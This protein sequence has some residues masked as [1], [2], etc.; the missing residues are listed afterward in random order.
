MPHELTQTQ[1]LGQNDHVQRYEQ[2]E[3]LRRAV[4]KSTLRKLDFILLPFL[5]LLFLFNAID[6]SNIGNA[7]SAHFTSDLGLQKDDL[8][9][10]VA[11]FFAFFVALQPVGAALGRKYGMVHFVPT[12]MA[13][14]G[15]STAL[16]VWVRS[17]WQ[18]YSLRIIIGCLEAGFYPVTVSYL[19]L[20][21]TRFE[22][23][24]RL[25][26]FYGQAAVGAAV[27]GILSYLVFSRFANEPTGGDQGVVHNGWK[28]WQVLFLLEGCTTIVI[29]LIGFLWL[30]HN[31][32]TAWFL[33]HQERKW[34]EQRIILDRVGE[35]G[36]SALESDLDG[37]EIDEEES[38]GLLNPTKVASPSTV[39]T[40]DRG[41]TPHDIVS[42]FL[43]PKIF[44]ILFCN[45][46]SAIPVYAFLVFFPLV[47]ASLTDTSNP[48]R[49]NLLTA[50]PNICGAITLY[51]F[52]WYSDRTRRRIGPILGGLGLLIF[53][54]LLV[55]MLPQSKG[56]AVP[57]YLALNVLFSG[58]FI[59]SP[60]T[61]AWISGNTPSPGKRALL[62]GI[63]GWGNLAGLFASLIFHPKYAADGYIVP[64]WWTLF[65]V[66]VAAAGYVL[67]WRNLIKENQRRQFVIRDWDEEDLAR[68]NAEGLGP[69]KRE[70]GVLEWIGTKLKHVKGLDKIAP[71][72]ERAIEGGREGD[73]K[74]TF[75]YGT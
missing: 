74:M 37:V 67:F 59:A 6:K 39:V 8:N 72:L 43:S 52:A 40:D 69:L 62:L 61:V 10:S 24:R 68:E 5:A 44:H 54:L 16:H 28:S 36:F 66:G 29:A 71:V 51:G 22:F 49:V 20:F 30:P 34:A 64:I 60:L 14:W 3:E 58:T 1:L 33:N 35:L 17:R 18:L 13:L 2:L 42:A 26:L 15:I 23:G 75:Q 21:Y 70:M 27:G 31:P 55:V 38:R 46:L 57:R 50:P 48:A 53:G 56:W 19:S 7:E 63:N 9:T 41:L 45:I 32:R 47:L 25:G 65:C 12:C 11:L 4:H 73:E